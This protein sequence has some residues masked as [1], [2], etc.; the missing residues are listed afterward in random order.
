MEKWPNFFI[1]GAP[2][3]GTTSLYEYLKNI[4]GIYMPPK[5]EPHYFSYTSLSNDSIIK[6]IRDKKKYLKLFA[7]AKDEKIIGDASTSYLAD[8]KAAELI[9]EVS[10]HAHILISLRDPVEA[11]FSGYLMQ[12]R[13]LGF[14]T[15]FLDEVQKGLNQDEFLGGGLNLPSRLYSKQIERYFD[16]FDSKQIKIIIFEEWIKN[17]KAIVQEILKFLGLKLLLDDFNKIVY[18]EYEI[19]RGKLLSKIRTN[20]QLS[21]ISKRILPQPTRTFLRYKFFVKKSVKPKMEKEDRDFLIRFYRDDVNK[22]QTLLGSKLP[23]VNF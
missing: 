13:N 18:N 16:I 15:S 2:K 21:M 4:P 10:P 5:K 7:N 12:K 19:S 14:K 20:N 23:W 6:P 22:L 8:P 3:A 9:H 11:I 1:V 17:T